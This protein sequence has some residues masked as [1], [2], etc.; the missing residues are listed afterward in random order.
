MKYPT[1]QSTP[2]RYKGTYKP[3][4]SRAL[5]NIRQILMGQKKSDRK[6]K[7][8]MTSNPSLR[9]RKKRFRSTLRGGGALSEEQLVGQEIWEKLRKKLS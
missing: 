7:R 8:I 2:D 6:K 4:H 9:D 1:P 5:A 3:D